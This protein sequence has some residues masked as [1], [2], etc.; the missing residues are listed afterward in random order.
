MS[1]N[2]LQFKTDSYVFFSQEEGTINVSE[3]SNESIRIPVYVQQTGCHYLE[4]LQI[5]IEHDEGLT[6]IKY[7]LSKNRSVYITFVMFDLY[8]YRST[9]EQ[10]RRV[11]RYMLRA[12]VEY[13][14]FFV[15]SYGRSIKQC[16]ARLYLTFPRV[17]AIPCP[18]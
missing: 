12:G 4:C 18:P 14:S 11:C 8:S 10:S 9:L 1:S 3:T 15:Q 6:T 2:L 16:I 7:Q 5:F 13:G 17:V